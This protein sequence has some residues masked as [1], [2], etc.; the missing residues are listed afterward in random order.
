MDQP[1]RCGI[2][3]IAD[4]AT[5]TSEE[6]HELERDVNH[7]STEQF[8]WYRSPNQAIRKTFGLMFSFET[9]RNGQNVVLVLRAQGKWKSKVRAEAN[10]NAN[11]IIQDCWSRNDIQHLFLEGNPFF[12]PQMYLTVKV[13]RA[14]LPRV[15]TSSCCHHSMALFWDTKNMLCTKMHDLECLNSLPIRETCITILG[16]HVLF[17]IL[18]CQCC[19]THTH[20]FH[21][22]D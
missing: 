16:E 3:S 22:E 19:C 1:S 2:L 6:E 13:A 17:F 5:A 4:L 12:K 14:E 9:H 20:S 7:Y 8:S 10:M 21:C 11:P 18:H 15:M